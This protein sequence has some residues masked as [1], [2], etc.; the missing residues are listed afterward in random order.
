MKLRYFAVLCFLAFL[1]AG[2]ASPLPEKEPVENLKHLTVSH[3]LEVENTDDRFVL[4]DDNS[5]L[6]AGRNRTEAD[7]IT[8]VSGTVKPGW[9]TLFSG[10][11]SDYSG[12]SAVYA[13]SPAVFAFIQYFNSDSGLYTRRRLCRPCSVL[14]A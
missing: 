8:A 13:W 1:L 3:S 10:K 6:A 11:P 5:T 7:R 2:C 9:Q 14:Y 4:V 12:I